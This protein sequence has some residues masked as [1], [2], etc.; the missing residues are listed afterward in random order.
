MMAGGIIIAS[1]GGFKN[2][3]YT[4]AI[5]AFG[6]GLGTVLLG[7]VPVFGFTFLLWR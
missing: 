2:K 4:M 5:S 1:W 6:F 3:T 7:I